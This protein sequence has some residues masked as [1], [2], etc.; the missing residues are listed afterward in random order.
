MSRQF[1]NEVIKSR[2]GAGPHF[3]YPK[4]GINL[5]LFENFARFG[6]M[7]SK[8]VSLLH[9]I[10]IDSARE[11]LRL[12]RAKNNS[13]IDY[14]DWQKR[15]KNR[16]MST[17]HY[18]QLTEKGRLE[19]E[20]R[21]IPEYEP[22]AGSDFEHRAYSVQWYASVIAGVKADQGAELI[23]W[24]EIRE[25]CDHS[26]AIQLT[27]HHFVK[28]DWTPFGVLHG[29]SHKFTRG[30]EMDRD[31][32]RGAKIDNKF[33]AHAHIFENHLYEKQLSLPGDFIPFIT[34]SERRKQRLMRDLEDLIADKKI[35]RR[36]AALFG[37][38]VF[39][40]YDDS[41]PLDTRAYTMPYE[42]VGYEPFFFNQP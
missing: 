20:K 41:N 27:E 22:P 42:R 19:N 29:D 23:E 3:I 7:G 2:H 39:P 34:V 4:R 37:F 10:P 8:E 16:L 38:A 21:G 32:E 26:P 14:V 11:K 40:D 1:S 9:D 17:F 15:N 5:P 6:M 28:T 12:L 30:P 33:L 36:Y 31:T 35:N 13:Y 24:P 18:Y 25:R